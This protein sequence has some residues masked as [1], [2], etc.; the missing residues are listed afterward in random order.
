MFKNDVKH[1]QTKYLTKDILFRASFVNVRRIYDVKS[2][3][4]LIDL[5]SDIFA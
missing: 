3:I 1:S 5:Y 2:T 4:E